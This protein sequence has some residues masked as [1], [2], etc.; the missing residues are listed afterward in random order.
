[1]RSL[2]RPLPNLAWRLWLQGYVH[3]NTLTEYPVTLTILDACF[4]GCNGSFGGIRAR[5][6]SKEKQKETVSLY[7]GAYFLCVTDQDEQALQ[8]RRKGRCT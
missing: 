3:S 7:V 4:Q 6:I 8:E 1:M 5:R 2:C